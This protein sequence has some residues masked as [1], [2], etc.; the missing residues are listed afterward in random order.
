M[1]DYQTS[2]DL[3]DTYMILTFAA[4]PTGEMFNGKMNEIFK[5]LPNLIG[6][7]DD[8][9]ILGYDAHGKDHDDIL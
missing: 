3:G 8:I 4:A 9:L 2:Q 7:A 6:I 5:D 1:K